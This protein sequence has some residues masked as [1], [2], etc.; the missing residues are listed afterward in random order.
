MS[1]YSLSDRNVKQYP[2]AEQM[3]GIL[4]VRLD[5]ALY[6]ANVQYIRERIE[7]YQERWQVCLPSCNYIRRA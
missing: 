7:H 2:E 3:D 4:L 5:A 6:F 1:G